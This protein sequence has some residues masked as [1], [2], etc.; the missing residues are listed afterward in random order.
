MRIP[1]VISVDV[2]C[3]INGALT[4]PERATPLGPEC[5]FRESGG[6]DHGLGL[7]LRTLH[8]HGL[9][10]SFFLETLCARFF[11][12]DA[13]RRI[14]APIVES[15][16]HE[17][18]LHLHPEWRYFDGPGWRT[19]L[20]ARR[21]Q[22]WRPNPRLGDRSDSEFE[23]LLTEAVGYFEQVVGRGPRAFR[24]GGLST[25][26]Q[27]YGVLQRQG[28]TAS[29]SV[30]LAIQRPRDALLHL[31]HGHAVIDGVHEIPVT[32]FTDLRVGGRS[33]W[34]GLTITGCTDRE[35]R[36]LLQQAYRWQKGPVVLL[37]HPAE[38]SLAASAP[39]GTG[40]RPNAITIAR[41]ESLC[42]FLADAS[43]RFDVTT[44]LDIATHA[45]PVAAPVQAALAIG[46]W[47][48][49]RRA[50]ESRRMQAL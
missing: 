45:K 34:R 27:I 1:V 43:D 12:I 20:A 15:G 22:G 48:N 11:G 39:S 47:G 23:D 21:T 42:A 49:L 3:D 8:R 26:R 35:T 17:L 25:S 30:G 32:S 46:P 14:A 50:L 19:D 37:T 41:L 40:F 10:G 28:F 13:L 6:V 31:P 4:F 24:S 36:K 5:V 44:V 7:I 29:S 18:E 2:E 16:H 9:R 38:F 33:H